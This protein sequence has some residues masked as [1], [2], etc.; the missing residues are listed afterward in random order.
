MVCTTLCMQLWLLVGKLGCPWSNTGR[1]PLV[2][3]KSACFHSLGGNGGTE[4]WGRTE[5]KKKS[6]KSYS[7]KYSKFIFLINQCRA[8]FLPNFAIMSVIMCNVAECPWGDKCFQYP[9]DKLYARQG[10]SSGAVNSPINRSGLLH[11]ERMGDFSGLKS[12]S[13]IGRENTHA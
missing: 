7:Q 6:P 13:P 3:M 12:N 4:C 8:N 1:A 9:A 10:E 5:G 11:G 2:I